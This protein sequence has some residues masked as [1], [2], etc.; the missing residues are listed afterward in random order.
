MSE[1]LDAT[2]IEELRLAL[3]NFGSMDDILNAMVRVIGVGANDNYINSTFF[4]GN[5]FWT[6]SIQEK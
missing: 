2:Q 3:S 6:S 5:I 1:N 4:R